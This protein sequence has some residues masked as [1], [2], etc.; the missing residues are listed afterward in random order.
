MSGKGWRQKANCRSQS[1][2]EFFAYEKTSRDNPPAHLKALCDACLV[3]GPCLSQALHYEEYGY[4]AGTTSRERVVIR[5]TLGIRLKRPYE[6][7]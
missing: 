5:Q 6:K 2:S 1:V 4:W 7:Y 3:V